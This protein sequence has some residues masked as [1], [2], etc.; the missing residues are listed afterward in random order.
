M[1]T[2]GGKLAIEATYFSSVEFHIQAQ[3]IV[4]LELLCVVSELIPRVHND[5]I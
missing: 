4:S 1:R 5:M 3:F 2:T